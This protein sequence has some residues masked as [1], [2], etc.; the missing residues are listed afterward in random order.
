MTTLEPES[1]DFYRERSQHYADFKSQF[2][3]HGFANPS[4][5]AL[6]GDESLTA[7]LTS[8]ASGNVGLDAG[9]GPGALDL[10]RLRNNGYEVSG[11][12]AVEENIQVA[13]KLHPE[14]S[15][16]LSVADLGTP[17][18]YQSDSFDFIMCNAVIQH[19]T[20]SLLF[21]ITIP[22]LIRVLRPDGVLQLVF[23]VGS[24]IVNVHD[25]EY[26]VDRIFHLY[27]EEAILSRLTELGCSLIEPT[28]PNGLGGL[29]YF[30]DNK[31]LRHCALYARK[32][33]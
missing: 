28:L 24:G 14:L 9:C 2:S 27:T 4:H 23:K 32:S 11:F 12:D 13:V 18:T 29:M 31:P 33:A 16:Y 1:L 15:P 19:I 21:N 17:L 26:G 20:P 22:E 30:T 3:E 10:A 7:F 8:L 25:G 5:P 6:L